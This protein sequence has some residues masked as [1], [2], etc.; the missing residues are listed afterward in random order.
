MF[1]QQ[2]RSVRMMMIV[3][4]VMMMMM[5]KDHDDNKVRGCLHQQY[6]SVSGTSQ[7]CQGGLVETDNSKLRNANK[8]RKISQN[9]NNQSSAVT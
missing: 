3:M 1:Y 9:H 4:I 6:R 2:Y 8:P 5:I 7:Y